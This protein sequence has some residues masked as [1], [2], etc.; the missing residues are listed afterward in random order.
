VTRCDDVATS[1][2]GETA[3]ERGKGGDAISWTDVNLSGSKKLRK[4]MWSI[5]LVQMDGEDLK[6]Q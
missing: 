6:Q 2:G 3:P 4:F 1:A 5:Q